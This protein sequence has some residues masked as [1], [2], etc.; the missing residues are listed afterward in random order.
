VIIAAARTGRISANFKINADPA[1]QDIGHAY[2][3]H[4]RHTPALHYIRH[5]L[6]D[7]NSRRSTI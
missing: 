7:L 2:F 3:V 6:T 5:L 1:T 4:R